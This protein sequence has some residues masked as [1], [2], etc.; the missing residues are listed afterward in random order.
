MLIRMLAAGAVALGATAA[1]PAK[2]RLSQ[3]PKEIKEVK[4]RCIGDRCAIY[5]GGYRVGS[6]REEEGRLVVRDKRGRT[7]VKVEQERE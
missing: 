1:L 4:S 6:M 7:V 3:R 5:V 2:E